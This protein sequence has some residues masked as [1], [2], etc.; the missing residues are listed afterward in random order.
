MVFYL[1]MR[2]ITLGRH[3]VIPN[4][5]L[6]N[7]FTGLVFTYKCISE[8]R[9]IDGRWLYEI[10]LDAQYTGVSDPTDQEVKDAIIEGLSMFGPHEKS[11]VQSA[12]DLANVLSS[13]TWQV[14]GDK[15]ELQ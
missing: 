10:E 1:S 4:S 11:S 2:P 6:D 8:N 9:S 14:N 12:C 15:I 7:H 5:A 13:E 3:I